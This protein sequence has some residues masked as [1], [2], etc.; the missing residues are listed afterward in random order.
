MSGYTKLMASIVHSTIWREEMHIKVT[1]ITMLALA[2]QYGEVMA[3]IPGLAHSAGVSIPQCQEALAKFMSP[4]PFS[5]TPEDQ[6]RRIREIEGGWFVINHGKYRAEFCKEHA[7]KKNAERQKRHRDKQKAQ[8][9]APGEGAEDPGSGAVFA[10]RIPENTVTIPSRPD[11]YDSVISNGFVTE[12]NPI[13]EAVTSEEKST[14]TSGGEAPSAVVEDE[15]F[16]IKEKKTPSRKKTKSKP[17][18]QDNRLGALPTGWTEEMEE[19]FQYL[20]ERAPKTVWKDGHETRLSHGTQKEIRSLWSG[21]LKQ[22]PDIT[23]RELYVAYWFYVAD[24]GDSPYIQLLSTFYGHGKA[25]WQD[26]IETARTKIAE[27]ALA[28]AKKREAAAQAVAS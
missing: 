8:E 26:W 12:N 14:T 16:S 5:R 10:N 18:D 7:A 25:T 2:D 3:S 24:C 15:D 17:F 23:P 9:Q 6:G 21:I 1:W 4:D 28:E 11:R 13:A 20:R 22:N 19:F 27:R